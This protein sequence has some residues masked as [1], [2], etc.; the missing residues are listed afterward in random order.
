MKKICQLKRDKKYYFTPVIESLDTIEIATKTTDHYQTI[1][2]IT[3][4]SKLVGQSEEFLFINFLIQTLENFK[5][6]NDIIW[7]FKFVFVEIF[8]QPKN[9]HYR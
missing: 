6:S 8:L 3:Q 7:L 4:S 5:N 2:N 9:F 1:V